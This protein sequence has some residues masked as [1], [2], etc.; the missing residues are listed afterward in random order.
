M[1]H[2]QALIFDVD[3]TLAETERDGHRVAF[4]RAFAEAGLPWEWSIEL[5]GDLLEVAGGKERIQFYLDCV[6]AAPIQSPTQSNVVL[7]RSGGDRIRWIT[8]LH[9]AKISHYKQLLREGIIPP[10][11][12]VQRLL[13]QARSQGV[14]LAIAT[15]S[16]PDNAIALLETAFAPNAP[17]WFEVIAAGDIVPAK[18][19]A[20][21]IYYYVLQAL[22]L[23]PQHCLVIEDSP[24][25]LQ[26]ALKAGLKT[27][28]TVN[29]Y[30]RHH[31]FSGAALVLDHL[32]E[33]DCPFEVIAGNAGDFTYFDVALAEWLLSQ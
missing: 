32:G 5:Y 16:A 6:S 9:T 7:P 19:P 21:D 23:E 10:R 2:L 8:A 11:P 22:N 27:V 26:A 17:S 1:P 15:T 31:D 14:Q 4:N 13:Q 24:Q 20:P 3:G 18:K 28:V 33:P 30:T 12:G 25:G 29:N